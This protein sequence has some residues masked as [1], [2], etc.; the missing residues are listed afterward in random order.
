[1]GF[2]LAGDKVGSSGTGRGVGNAQR[3]MNLVDK[4]VV[5]FGLVR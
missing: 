3:V 4:R 5:L 2:L 1:M